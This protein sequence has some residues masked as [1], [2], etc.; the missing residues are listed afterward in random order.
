[1]EEATGWIPSSKLEPVK[2]A[3]TLDVVQQFKEHVK[4]YASCRSSFFFNS[5]KNWKEYSTG[6]ITIPSLGTGLH[7]YYKALFVDLFEREL[8]Q[9]YNGL[10]LGIVLQFITYLELLLSNKHTINQSHS[11]QKRWHLNIH[12]IEDLKPMVNYENRWEKI[13]DD[14][15]LLNCSIKAIDTEYN[16]RVHGRIMRHCVGGYARECMLNKTNIIEMTDSP[17]QKSTIQLHVIPKTNQV[18]IKEHQAYLNTGPKQTHLDAADNLVKLINNGSIPLRQERLQE[19]PSPAPSTTSPTIPTC[20]PRRRSAA[21]T[22]LPRRSRPAGA[23]P[24]TPRRSAF[25]PA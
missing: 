19:Q 6:K 9:N 8:A 5:R 17:G 4:C 11:L 13:I 24:T 10:D 7:D 25:A 16:L 12:A 23:A 14:I 1:M 3:Q 22:A 18:K 21:S 2:F 20:R 15:T